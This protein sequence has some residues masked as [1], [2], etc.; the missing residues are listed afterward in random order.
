MISGVDEA[1]RGPAMG[2]LVVGVVY[3]ESDEALKEI[4]VKDSKKLTPK[5]R[6]R[7]YD[8]IVEAADH[9][10]TVIISAEEI[11]EQRKRISLNEI[12]LN[13]FAEGVTKW[14]AESIYADCPD[15]NEEAFGFQ[16]VL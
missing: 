3:V 4:G 14:K 12:E 13:M 11:D 5:A 1:G 8:L 16:C 7:M 6:D 10:T 2:P 15:I 9:W